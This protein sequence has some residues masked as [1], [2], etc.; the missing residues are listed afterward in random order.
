[1]CNPPDR[2][3]EGLRAALVVGPLFEDSE[4]TYPLHR[5]REAGAQVTILGL[6]AGVEVKGKNGQ[7]LFTDLAAAA[8]TPDDFDL[9]VLPGGYGPDKVRS[10]P[11]VQRLV[12]EIDRRRRPI[13]F[14]CHA[15]WI[16]A[17]AGILGG[18]RVTSWPSI[19]DDLSNAGAL[20]EDAE[21]VVDGNLVS[22]RKPDDLPAFMRALIEVA[23]G[24]A[25][26]VDPGAAVAAVPG[27]A[28]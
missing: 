5:L 12:Q 7:V 22:S 3:L 6:A 8:A 4:A 1:M 24:P 27:G 13:G 2:P 17:S 28:G 19:A 25:A 11:G 21:V 20:W 9:L 18:R 15:G 14:I 10:D 16:P 26:R 23:A